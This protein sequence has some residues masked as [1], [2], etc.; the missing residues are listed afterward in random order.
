MPQLTVLALSLCL[1]AWSA[2]A[3]P[4]PPDRGQRPTRDAAPRA[5]AGTASLTGR[6]AAA[7][8]GRGLSRARVA[9]SSPDLRE[10]FS[11]LTDQDGRYTISGLPAAT[12]TISASKTGFVML[13]YG[14]SR[15]QRSGTRVRLAQGQ[16]LKDIDIRLPRGGVLTGRVYDESGEPVVRAVV[17]AL[18]F[19]YVQGE[20]RL[21]QMGSGES[22]DR[23]QFRIYGLLPGTYVVA[24]SVRPEPALRE[25]AEERATLSFAPTYYPGVSAVAEAAPI[26]LGVQQE[27]PTVDFL[28]QLVPTARVSGS[29]SSPAGPVGGSSVT[30]VAEDPFGAGPGPG[31]TFGARV[32]EDGTFTVTGVAPGRYHAVAR[33]TPMG[34]RRGVRLAGMTP[35]NVAGTDVSGVSIA[36]SEGGTIAGTIVT[37]SGAP[38]PRPSDLGQM[39]I[40]SEATAQLNYASAAA[41]AAG[42]TARVSADGSFVVQ[43]AFPAP[44][45]LRV[46]GLPAGLALDGVYL[47]GRDVSEEPFEVR[48]SQPVTGVRVVLTDRPTEL[49]GTVTDGEGRPSSDLYVVAFST[50]SAAW[51]PRSRRV[52]GVRPGADGVYRFRGL[53][54][55]SYYVATAADVESGSWYDPVLLEELQKTAQRV[56][57]GE[58][59][60]KTA[61]LKWTPLGTVN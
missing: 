33:G 28:L 55:G 43:N 46:A 53:P 60:T 25:G 14:A 23:G 45:Y 61:D 47:D 7:D 24:A 44:Q 51:R 8:T 3:T 31:T 48:P 57:L 32:M 9:V 27:V 22:D 41:G 56:S 35:V 39:R 4:Q 12:Y 13:S 38:L 37:R 21:T 54:P 2:G 26:A 18:R 15:S 50:D 59:E 16:E 6:V 29:V 40:F 20:R 52:Q 30:L 1:L 19:Q 42:L 17:R 11:A 10:G 34:G 5:V 36:L 49:T 58:G